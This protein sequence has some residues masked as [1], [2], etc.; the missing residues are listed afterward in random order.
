MCC[1][2]LRGK[3]GQVFKLVEKATKK[4]W[5]GKFIKAYSAK[6]KENV[7]QEIGIMNSLHHPKLVQCIDAFEGKS[8][9]VMVLEMYV[10]CMVSQL[11][12]K[13]IISLAQ[14]K[15]LEIRGT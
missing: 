1:A 8:D 14:Q 3:F 10:T 7:R 11:S 5:A 13:S 6:E 12:N 2:C 4:V 15:R 9:I